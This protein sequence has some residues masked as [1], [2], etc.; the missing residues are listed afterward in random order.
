MLVT[1]PWDLSTPARHR[2]R[3]S[4]DADLRGLGRRPPDDLGSRQL[5]DLRQRRQEEAGRP[6]FV[7]WLTA[8]EQV[9]TF[10]LATGDLPIRKSVGQDKAVLDRDEREA[11]GHATFVENLTT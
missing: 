9:K 10:S 6:D 7:K 3:R 5:G 4:G 1:G 2:L 11:A 8:P